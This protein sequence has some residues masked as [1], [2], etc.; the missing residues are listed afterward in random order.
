MGTAVRAASLKLRTG[1]A[2]AFLP[3]RYQEF[4]T[5][6]D[7]VRPDGM[8]YQIGYGDIVTVADIKV[9][10]FVSQQYYKRIAAV[11]VKWR[12]AAV[13]KAQDKRILMPVYTQV[14]LV[15]MGL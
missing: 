7:L 5:D 13:P 8:G 12:D 2:T 10:G 1:H 11:G 9:R 14:E 6:G 3:S 15:I 4:V